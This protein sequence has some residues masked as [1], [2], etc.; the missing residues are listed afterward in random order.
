LSV[1]TAIPRTIATT[2]MQRPRIFPSVQI[3]RALPQRGLR[4][5]TNK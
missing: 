1:E 2:I 4:A 3:A 5:E